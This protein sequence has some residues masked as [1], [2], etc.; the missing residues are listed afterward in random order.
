MCLIL[1]SYKNHP[2]YKLI[3]AANRDEF[4]A[5]PT[6]PADYWEDY[7]EIIAGRDLEAMGTWMG[8]N[9]KLGKI[10]ML[11]NYRDLTKLK[12]VAPSR[13]A[14]V[15]DFLKND[16][17]SEDYY[18]ELS[19]RL[20]KFNGFNLVL[21]KPDELSYFSSEFQ[22]LKPLTSGVYGLSNALMNSPW[23]KVQK[24]KLK[25]EA[26]TEERH[27]EVENLFEAMND[28]ELA[29]DKKLPDTGVG[30][31]KER[32]LSPMFIKSPQ[33]GSRCTTVIM[34]D[35]N[36]KVLYAER[37]YDTTTFAYDTIYH[38]FKI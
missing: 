21:G 11:T 37:T 2:R 13:G 12:S 20:N 31:D 7:P 32:M 38:K 17:T 29:E 3:I 10:S 9:Q 15:S 1:F 16:S 5:R 24:G 6:A 14:L 23:P 28:D 34:V 19:T 35:H 25:F 8:M 27:F 18:R 22:G 33:Y 36:D 30:I 26:I 4:Y